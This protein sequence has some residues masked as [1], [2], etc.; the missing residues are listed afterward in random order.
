VAFGGLYAYKDYGDGNYSRDP[1]KGYES[2]V[3]DAIG[4]IATRMDAKHKPIK[5]RDEGR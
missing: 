4:Y 3:M 5:E 2:N 1:N